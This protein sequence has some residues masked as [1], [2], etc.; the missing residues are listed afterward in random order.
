MEVG[1]LVLALVCYLLSTAA[2]VI[3][4]F[5]S[6]PVARVFAPICLLMAFLCHAAAIAA[7][8][9]IV[10]YFAVT[11]VYEA[12]SF[13][14]CLTAGIGLLVQYRL[15]VSILGAI[16]SPIG[17][18]LTLGVYIFYTQARALPPT[19]QSTWF[20]IHV[21]AAFLGNAIFAVAFGASLV[22]LLKE[23]QLKQKKSSSLLRRLPSLET[24]DVL[25]YRSLSW[26]FLLLTVGLLTGAVWAEY[27]WGQFWIWE[28]RLILSVV[29][30]ILYALLLHYRSAGWR[31]RSAAMLTIMCFAVLVVSFVSVQFFPGR[32]GGQ[33]G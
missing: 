20:P 26:G 18:V 27:A 21:T 9:Y 11:D 1:L 12:T 24:L 22:Y 28:P 3:G 10:G 15:P 31:G 5:T 8:S 6:G 25:N 17:F 33:F 30:W 14:A 32:H 2:F 13:F 4:L 29:T 7:R 23:K 19:L 16:V